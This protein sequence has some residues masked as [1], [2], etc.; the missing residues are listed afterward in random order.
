MSSMDFVTASQSAERDARGYSTKGFIVIALVLGGFGLWS[1]TSNVAGAVV[2][3]GIVTVES[4]VKKVQHRTGGVVAE[5]KVSNGDKVAA[6][7]LLVR[8]DETVSL[9][10]LHMIN[11]QLDE[12][13]MREARL[14][15]ERDGSDTITLPADYVGR[16]TQPEIAKRIIG[17]TAFFNS[18]RELQEGQRL[19]LGEQVSQL[20]EEITGFTRQIAA[21][22][23]ESRIIADEL[24]SM[25][26]LE[27]DGL[28]TAQRVNQLRRDF[29]RLEGDLGYLQAALAQAKGKI[30]EIEIEILRIDQEFR[31]GTIEELRDNLAEQA[32]LLE[33]RTA[34]E[35]E[36]RRIDIRA[37]H[38]GTVH[39]LSVHTVGGVINPAEP[40]MLIVPEDED[41]I[42][43]ARIATHDIDMVQTGDGNAFVRLPAFNQ[44]T[45]PELIGR[46]IDV[47]AD[48]TVDPYTGQPYYLARISISREEQDKLGEKRLVPGM[49][50]EVYVKTEDR[51]VLSY[52]AKPVMDQMSRAFRER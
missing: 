39:E 26:K 42:V 12:L 32:E 33:R 5:I 40:I 43:E 50:A 30:A 35:D 22:Q 34:A 2:S 1:A 44:H 48:M 51:T 19:Q 15:A 25:A 24:Q 3:S 23:S 11:K 10:N 20:R 47:S 46:V 18:R 9:A 38:S 52:L 7:D 28:V 41:L 29:A 36:L 14:E 4:K 27:E 31:S 6:G 17:E 13:Q 49:P 37:P 8:L 16:D 21:K 45:T